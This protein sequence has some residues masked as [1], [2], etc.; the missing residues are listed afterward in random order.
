MKNVYI[1]CYD[2]CEFQTLEEAMNHVQKMPGGLSVYITDIVLYNIRFPITFYQFIF[3][4]I[5]FWFILP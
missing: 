3:N 5:I 1:P 2:R 4:N